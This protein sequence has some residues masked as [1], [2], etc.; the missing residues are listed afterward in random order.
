[1]EATSGWGHLGKAL[2]RRRLTL[3]QV[4][5]DGAWLGTTVCC[6]KCVSGRGETIRK[7]GKAVQ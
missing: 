2:Q 3:N 6:G 7:G 1:M 4:S 5:K